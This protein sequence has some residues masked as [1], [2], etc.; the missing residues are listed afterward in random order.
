MADCGS[1]NRK[2]KRFL[3]QEIDLKKS[4][5]A[6]PAALVTQSMDQATARICGS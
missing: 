1:S 4:F 2:S 5:H 3:L 6:K